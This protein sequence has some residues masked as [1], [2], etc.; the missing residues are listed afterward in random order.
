MAQYSST[1]KRRRVGVDVCKG[2]AVVV[3]AWPRGS[4]AARKLVDHQPGG[5]F[6]V[7]EGGLG[8]QAVAGADDLAEG[9]QR[10]RFQQY[11]RLLLPD[12]DLL[13]NGLVVWIVVDALGQGVSQDRR[14]DALLQ[15]PRLGD[16]QLTPGS[17]VH[18]GAQV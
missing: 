12:V 3:M 1:V 18:P 2:K 15:H 5:E 14:Q 6:R 4:D 10:E 8:R 16:R 9:F 17:P 11:R 7:E 13:D